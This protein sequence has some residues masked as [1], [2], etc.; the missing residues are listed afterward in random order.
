MRLMAN[1]F[2]GI[3]LMV[4]GLIGL[5]IVWFIPW[6]FVLHLGVLAYFPY[7]PD[8]SSRYLRVAG[9]LWNPI[10]NEWVPSE[11]IPKSCKNALVAA[12]DA[13][14]YE[15][16]GI[17]VDSLEKNYDRN[18]VRKKVKGG[19]T[20]TQQLVKNAF[21]SRDRSYVRKA[22]EIVGA[23]LLD[24]TMSKDKQ[25]TWYFN[26][27]EFGPNLYGLDSAAE[28]YFKKE[29]HKLNTRECVSLVAILPSPKKWNKS[30]ETKRP[31][32]FFNRRVSVIER[33]M[34][35]MGNLAESQVAS[36]NSLPRLEHEPAKN[37]AD[38][39]PM[40]SMHEDEDLI[41][42]GQDF[43]LNPEDELLDVF[44]ETETDSDEPVNIEDSQDGGATESS[45]TIPDPL[46]TESIEPTPTEP[47][48]LPSDDFTAP[49]DSTL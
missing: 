17:D 37:S 4:F 36:K 45:E 18:K 40:P 9:P 21:L 24:A 6:V 22:R 30:L 43:E 48:D 10:S 12:E 23:V 20:I 35:I 13:R 49:L 25:L 44:K 31:T 38:L 15:H 7:E 47:T 42:P 3:G 11:N 33:R 8:G 26:L 1:L 34:R 41:I 39:P 5:F 14:F 2:S 28:H 16:F 19:S 46:E 27:V 32:A 29:P